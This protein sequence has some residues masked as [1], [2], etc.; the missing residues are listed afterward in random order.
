V[1][2]SRP[3]EAEKG[4]EQGGEE[5]EGEREGTA[6]GTL[7]SRVGCLHAIKKNVVQCR[8]GPMTVRDDETRNVWMQQI[9]DKG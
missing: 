4:T 1:R 2:N 5:T 6:T 7:A 3:T 8:G 9:I